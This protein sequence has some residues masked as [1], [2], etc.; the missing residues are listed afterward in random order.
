MSIGE[1]RPIRVVQYGLGPIGQGAAKLILEKAKAGQLELVGAIDIDPQKANKTLGSLVNAPSDT[2][3]SPDAENVL[4]ETQPDVVI[5]TTS[6]FM[7]QVEQQL[8]QC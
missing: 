7:P 2:I 6:S 8:L 4:A 1:D 5:H 3:I